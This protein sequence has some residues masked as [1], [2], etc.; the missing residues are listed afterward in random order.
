MLSRYQL[1]HLI[2]FFP[3]YWVKQME[4]MKESVGNN[5]RLDKSGGKKQLVHHFTTNE[6][7]KYIG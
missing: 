1:N 2:Q 6:L 3:G 4:K 7:W 5:N